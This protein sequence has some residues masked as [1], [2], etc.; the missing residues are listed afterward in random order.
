MTMYPS[1]PSIEI[2]ITTRGADIHYHLCV[3][4]IT[5]TSNPNY[6]VSVTFT[7]S[8]TSAREGQEAMFTRALEN[9]CDYLLVLDSD[10]VPEQGVIAK[11]LLANSEIVCAPVWH[12]SNQVKQAHLDIQTVIHGEKFLFNTGVGIEQIRSASFGCML[13][14][15][16]VLQKFDRAKEK[17]TYH[18]PL[19]HRKYKTHPSDSIFFAKCRHFKTKMKVNWDVRT[20]HYKRIALSTQYINRM[21]S[22]RRENV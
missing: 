1:K 22:I 5:A 20:E 19:I 2:G 13:V 4:L 12:Y 3:F 9:G 18:S 7:A 6:N 10:V 21:E 16:S 11:L 17:F 14:K 8:P 15:R